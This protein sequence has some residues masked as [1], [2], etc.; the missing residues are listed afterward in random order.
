M[1]LDELKKT[2]QQYDGDLKKYQ[3]LNEEALRS[4]CM[5]KAEEAIV[6]GSGKASEYFRIAFCCLLIF[7]FGLLAIKVNNNPPIII[8]SAVVVMANMLSIGMS[9][10]KLSY[11]SLTHFG[12]YAVEASAGQLQRLNIMARR[13]RIFEVLFS[14]LL[15]TSLFILLFLGLT[16]KTL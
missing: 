3:L 1:E 12:D 6:E 5:H 15:A 9:I 2:W 10:Y 13:E 16:I 7:I 4:M 8:S 14:P 11:I